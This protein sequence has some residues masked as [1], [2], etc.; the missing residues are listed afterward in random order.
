MTDAAPAILIVQAF[1]RVPGRPQT[2]TCMSTMACLTDN[3]Q[4]NKIALGGRNYTPKTVMS[5]REVTFLDDAGDTQRV[6]IR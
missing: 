3:D 1:D 2:I 6:V 5:N 4:A